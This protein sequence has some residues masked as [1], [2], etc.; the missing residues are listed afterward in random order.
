MT[1]WRILTSWIWLFELNQKVLLLEDASNHALK[2]KFV[3]R[4]NKYVEEH[5]LAYITLALQN[6]YTGSSP[7]RAMKVD[8]ILLVVGAELSPNLKSKRRSKLINETEEYRCKRDISKVHDT[9]GDVDISWN[10]AWIAKLV[11]CCTWFSASNRTLRRLM[12]QLL[13]CGHGRMSQTGLFT[14]GLPQKK[15]IALGYRMLK[16]FSGQVRK[17]EAQYQER[18]HVT[19][20]TVGKK[21]LYLLN[22]YLC[23]WFSVWMEM[24]M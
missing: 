3:E 4:V 6:H 10:R 15:E 2:S 7:F 23:W 21:L 24:M 13:Y 11:N 14:L 22:R 20:K 18:H 16:G 5:H 1:T 12:W 19:T 17:S 8:K 9:K